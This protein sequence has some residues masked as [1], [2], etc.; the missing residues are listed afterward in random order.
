MNITL[1]PRYT[2]DIHDLCL[3]YEHLLEQARQGMPSHA[4][5]TGWLDPY[6]HADDVFLLRIEERARVIR[7]EAEVVV[8]IGVGG[9]NNAARTVIEATESGDRPRILYGGTSTSPH[10]MQ[11]VLDEIDGKRVHLIV[12]AKNFETLEPG[13][14]FRVL[15][16]HLTQTC[17]AGAA[18][19]ITAIG[20]AGGRLEQL[21]LEHRWSFFP[22]P[23]DVGGRYSMFSAVA[24][25]PMAVAGLDIRSYL[26]SAAET[27]SSLLAIEAQDNP[28]LRYAALRRH[29]Y[30]DGYRGEVLSFFDPR[31]QYFLKWWIQLFAESEGK[32]GNGLLPS[33]C[34]FSEELHSM[35]QFLQDGT[36]SFFET[37]LETRETCR[38]PALSGDGIDDGFAYLDESS[39]VDLN[40]SARD[41]AIWAHHQHIPTNIISVGAPGEETF[42]RLFMFFALACVFSCEMA[43]VNPFDQPGVEAYKTM[44][45]KKLKGT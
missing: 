43:Q 11:S 24:L 25:L 10:A 18:H 6:A 8:I 13:A 2:A 31:M 12:I 33:G 27:K 30:L 35:G 1:D 28:P 7:D 23:D 44:M 41:A 37:F 9:S 38:G 19:R 22:F 40:H 20:S 29:L 3:R 15:R 5:S 42:G 14:S 26:R 4:G 32:G 16:R 39:F 17:G 45:F 36:P 21:A 34:F